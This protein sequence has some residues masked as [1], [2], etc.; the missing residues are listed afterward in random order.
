MRLQGQS[1]ASETDPHP[2]S[3]LVLVHHNTREEMDLFEI[4]TSLDNME[5]M[6]A[7]DQ[8][9]LNEPDLLALINLTA[10]HVK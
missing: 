2:S 10:S 9:D 6:V 7:A 4:R 1:W 5:P 8:T 3:S